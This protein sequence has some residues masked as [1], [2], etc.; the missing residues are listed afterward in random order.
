MDSTVSIKRNR[1]YCFDFIKGVACICVVFMH[2]EFPGKLGIVVQCVSRFSVPYFFMVSGYYSY[3]TGDTTKEEKWNRAKKRIEHLSR[4]ILAVAFLYIVFEALRGVSNQS[5]SLSKWVGFLIFNEPFIAGQ[6][7]FLFALLYDYIL[8]AFIDRWELY[9]VA[10]MMIP[11]F[12][13]LYI[14]LAQGAYLVGIYVPNMYYR[15]F[16]IEGFPF[17][18]L[19]H[20][21]HTYQDKI[22]L[23]NWE[24]VSIVCVMTVLCLIERLLMGKNFGVNIVTFPQVTALFLFGVKNASLFKGSIL[25]KIGTKLSMFVYILHPA[26]W[27]TL[28]VIYEKF[29]ID[30]NTIAL[31]VMP[32]V[33]LSLTMACSMILSDLNTRI[34]RNKRD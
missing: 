29:G 31:Y 9:R 20:F 16:L 26:I 4:I 12:V 28:E 21:I 30:K 25:Q 27:H 8:Y 34:T 5:I 24:L 22:K 19:G 18:M 2:C 23:N 15:N 33:V 17:F 3:Y 1:N 32:I 10:Y 11:F 6:M 7:W 14:S 13:L